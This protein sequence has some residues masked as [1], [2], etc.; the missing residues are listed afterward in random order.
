[1][2]NI[3]YILIFIAI[4]SCDDNEI[5]PAYEKVGSATSTVATISISND[6]PQPGE[7]VTVT[8]FYVN[9][10][11]DPLK[12]VEVR[13]K[14]GS[15]SY[16]VLES[17]DESSGTRDTEIV[18]EVSFVAPPDEVEVTF[19]LVISSQKEFPQI[20]RASMEVID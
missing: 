2:K 7:T 15:G 20:L 17:F 13:V 6:E 8:V 1:M 3:F 10:S 4:V 14:E 9:P 19:D 11:T 12:S 5:M 18:R 16:E